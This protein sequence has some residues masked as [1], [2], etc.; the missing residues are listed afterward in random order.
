MIQDKN[1]QKKNTYKARKL[2][3]KILKT[4]KIVF[5][6][7]DVLKTIIELFH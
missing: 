3:H 5:E 2:I 6:A 1:R 4:L 7:L